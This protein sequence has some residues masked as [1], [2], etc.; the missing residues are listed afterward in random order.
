MK[1]LIIIMLSLCC[2]CSVAKEIVIHT[3][4]EY[5]EYADRA[6]YL[7]DLIY[8]EYGVVERNSYF[9]LYLWKAQKEIS[10]EELIKANLFLDIVEQ[11]LIKYGKMPSGTYAE[12]F[13]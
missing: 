1:N 13:K 3:P 10:R 12:Q 11:R 6:G 5:K 4:T 7:F 8:K 9:G 2:I